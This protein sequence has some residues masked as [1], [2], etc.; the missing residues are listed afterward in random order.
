VRMKHLGFSSLVV[1]ALS[2]LA[3][4]YASDAALSRARWP[5]TTRAT[6]GPY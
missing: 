1:A 3:A 5:R 6:G 2:G 4:A